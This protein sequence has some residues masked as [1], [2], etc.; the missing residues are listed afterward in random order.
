M[1]LKF[2]GAETVI[3]VREGFVERQS[4]GLILGKQR[5]RIGDPDKSIPFCPLVPSMVWYWMNRV[6]DVFEDNPHV[7]TTYYPDKRVIFWDKQIRL[8]TEFLIVKVD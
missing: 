2:K 1:V 8:K 7:I 6:S 4:M 3:S 5:V